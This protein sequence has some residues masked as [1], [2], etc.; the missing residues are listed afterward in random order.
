MTK[1]DCIKT[2]CFYCKQQNSHINTRFTE[3]LVNILNTT[4]ERFSC[5]R[6]ADYGQFVSTRTFVSQWMGKLILITKTSP[7]PTQF[8]EV[9]ILHQLRKMRLDERRLHRLGGFEY[10]LF[11]NLRL[12]IMKHLSRLLIYT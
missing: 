4:L 9:R 8:L 10:D 2:N 11:T 12:F 5:S 6:Y 3:V 7:I 1:P